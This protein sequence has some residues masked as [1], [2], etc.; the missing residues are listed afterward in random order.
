MF[1]TQPR[2]IDLGDPRAGRPGARRGA[3]LRGGE[4]DRADDTGGTVM[5]AAFDLEEWMEMQGYGPGAPPGAVEIDER[6][7][8]E[9]HCSECGSASPEYRPFFNQASR[10]YRAFAVCSSCCHTEEF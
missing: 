7:C 4:A 3:Q 9:S 5:N 1:S 10:S 6:V 8:R 2:G